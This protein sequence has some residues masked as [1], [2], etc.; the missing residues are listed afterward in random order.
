MDA[1]SYDFNQGWLFGGRYRAGAAEPGYDDSG[2]T[3]VT[4]PHTVTALS[5]GDWDPASWQQ[6]WIYRKHFGWPAAPAAH[7][8]H[9]AGYSWTSTA[10]WSARPC[11]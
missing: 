9:A 10:C 2:F 5:W 4:L 8:A 3:P 6:V 1:R 7:P 11:C